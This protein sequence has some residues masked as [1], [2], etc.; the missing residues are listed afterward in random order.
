MI[1]RIGDNELAVFLKPVL[2]ALGLHDIVFRVEVGCY[3]QE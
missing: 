1:M 2:A 3:V